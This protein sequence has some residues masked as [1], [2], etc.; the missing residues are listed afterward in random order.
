MKF[1]S[2]LVLLAALS[3][4]TEALHHDHVRRSPHNRLARRGNNT[5]GRCRQ[6]KTP[7]PSPPPSQNDSDGDCDGDDNT[8]TNQGTNPQP[9][10]GPASS[11]SPAPSPSPS[12]S[13]SPTP[14]TSPAPSN[15]NGVIQVQ[16][17]TCGPN[18]ATEQVTQT[19]GPNGSIDWMNCGVNG[20]GWTPPPVKVT[21]L[22]TVDLD[23]AISQG[24]PFTTCSAFVWAFKQ[25]GQQFGL[26]PI[27]LASI[28]LQE[29]SCNPATVG[30][31][32]EQG[33]MQLTSDKCGD[34]PGG[35]CQD[36]G[37]NVM[38]GAKY[39]S[40]QLA[41]SDGNFFLALG[42]YNG[43]VEGMTVQYATRMRYT[44]CHA[45]NNL[46][47]LHQTVN[48]WLQNKDAYALHLGEYFNIADC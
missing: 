12:P 44:A 14:N 23:D 9:N 36:V 18:G 47:Y 35:N 19:T 40:S 30:G 34:A 15:S 20:A 21:D 11:P 31:N 48:G 28:A 22:I 27:L 10:N 3:V 29:S 43:W 37:Y 16:D 42:S 5:N 25:Y 45:Q 2:T 13:P 39:F 24:G 41:A 33:L 7:P 38:T 46:D 17:N 6:R 32:G 4:L 8:N 26:P 1:L